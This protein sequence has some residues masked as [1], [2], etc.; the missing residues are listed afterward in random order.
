MEVAAEVGGDDDAGALGPIGVPFVEPRHGRIVP[1]GFNRMKR[2]WKA[3]PPE[4]PASEPRRIRADAQRNLDTLLEAAKAVFAVSGVDAPVRE[5]AERA[6]IGV[7][8]VYRH[9]P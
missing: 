4:P 8:T 5:V 9:F 1:S 7:G 3:Q 2:R 6:G